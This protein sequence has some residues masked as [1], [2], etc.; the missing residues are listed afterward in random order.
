MSSGCSG[1][2]VVLDMCVVGS[3]VVGDYGVEMGT[4]E[5]CKVVECSCG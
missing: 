3:V 1:D 5:G 2:K 4:S